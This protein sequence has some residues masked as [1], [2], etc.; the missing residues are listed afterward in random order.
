MRRVGCSDSVHTKLKSSFIFNPP[1]APMIVC[2]CEGL[3]ERRI[4]EQIAAG[5]GNL[6]E[7]GR[8][9]GAGTQC[10]ACSKTLL[11]MIETQR[12]TDQAPPA[13]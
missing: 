6:R 9:C 4:R 11:R 7:L 10:G 3:N 2:V 8:K 1:G 13:R 5:C 12:S